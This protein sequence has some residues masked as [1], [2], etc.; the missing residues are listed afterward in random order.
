MK[1]RFEEAFLDIQPLVPTQLPH[2]D[3]PI[4]PREA[5]SES[6]SASVSA[7]AAGQ[8][9]P[10]VAQDS[11]LLL[12]QSASRVQ[13][14][15][16]IKGS[17]LRELSLDIPSPHSPAR[18]AAWALNKGSTTEDLC[19]AGFCASQDMSIFHFG[20]G[21]PS[22]QQH[23][24]DPAAPSARP[25][26]SRLDSLVQGV[27]VRELSTFS[28][29]ATVWSLRRLALLRVQILKSQ[30]IGVLRSQEY[31]VS[32]ANVRIIHASALKPTP[33]IRKH[34]ALIVLSTGVVLTI[35]L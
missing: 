11:L 29:L 34:R 13:V 33:R 15:D 21:Q 26:L 19:V 28:P 20:A 24:H 4:D 1:V 16:A 2:H 14:F 6:Q 30:A 12:L 22:S 7:T 8:K 5:E 25:A 35:Q 31:F 32:P 10:S 9:T 27:A 18:C 3:I 17:V 23:L